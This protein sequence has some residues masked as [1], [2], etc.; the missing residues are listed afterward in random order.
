MASFPQSIYNLAT[1]ASWKDATEPRGNKE[2]ETSEEKEGR[3]LLEH[4]PSSVVQSHSEIL[5]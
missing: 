5:F 4:Y 1:I 2:M 3:V